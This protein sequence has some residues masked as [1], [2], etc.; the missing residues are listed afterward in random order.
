MIRGR[1]LPLLA[2]VVIVAIDRLTKRLAVIHLFIDGEWRTKN[3]WS[4][5]KTEILN[6]TY[7]ENKG[8]AFGILQG[9]WWFLVL[10]TSF[11]ITGVLIYLLSDK[12]SGRLLMCALTLIVAGG[13]GN[14]I[15][16]VF[17][18]Y[19]VDFIDFRVINFAIFNIADISAVTGGFLL[20]FAMVR[21]EVRSAK[22]KKQSND[23]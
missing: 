22:L 3:I 1:L 2:I 18:G 6:L 7:C 8:A 13:A 9:Q 17:Q 23:E 16:R 4:I 15:D 19:V 20:L 5:G 14:L 10:F 21:E 12:V 11:M